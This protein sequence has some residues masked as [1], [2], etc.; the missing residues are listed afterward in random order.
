MFED[1]LAGDRQDPVLR[2]KILKADGSL[3][4]VSGTPII[5]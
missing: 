3:S 1:S 4:S 2:L 5:Y